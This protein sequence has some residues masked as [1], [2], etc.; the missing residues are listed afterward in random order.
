MP[1]REFYRHGLQRVHGR[2]IRERHRPSSPLELFYDLTFVATIG[3]ASVAF[4]DGIAAGE[5]APAAAA[6]GVTMLAILWAW[7][8]SAWFTS[9][10]DVDDWLFRIMTMAQMAGV[11][12]LG[13]GVPD[14]FR[15]FETGGRFAPVVM[16]AGYVII[17]IATIG[18]WMR[19]AASDP[20]NRQPAIG[21][22][23]VVGIAQCGW[24]AQLF[25]PLP[26]PLLLLWLLLFLAIEIAGPL[27]VERRAERG[28]RTGV[29]WH[30]EHI[31]ERYGLMAIITLGETVT[32]TLAS[33][34]RI[35]AARGWSLDAIVVIATGVVI[36]FS[37]WW[38]YYLIPSGPVLAVR[39]DK[40]VVWV[41]GHIVLFAAI[42]AV[43]AGLHVIGFTYAPRSH[44]TEQTAVISV[45]GP[46]LIVMLCMILLDAWLVSALLST[47]GYA[48]TLAPPIAAIV[49]SFAGVPLWGCLLVVAASPLSIIVTHESRDWRGMRERLQ[50]VLR[51]NTP[52]EPNP[53]PRPDAAV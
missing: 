40:F 35:S 11:I 22:A 32:G 23:V 34:A 52:A 50:R 38:A 39:R 33:A 13:I 20:P 37:L 46:V 36:S 9:A 30:P 1:Q 19:V 8:G 48:F 31:A 3:V 42:A 14:T 47:V 15:A 41:Y 6:F 4:A 24:A 17:R 49:L 7:T 5:P 10:F 44:V 18:Q 43:G 16:T 27:V 25:L 51:T 45:A 28:G 29:P 2:D 53:D 12:V 26:G 21:N